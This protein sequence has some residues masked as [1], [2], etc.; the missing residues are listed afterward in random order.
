MDK[1]ILCLDFDGVIHS[2]ERGWQNGEIYGTVTSGFWEWANEARK[3]FH[4]VVYSSRSKEPEMRT[5]M[6][7]WLKHQWGVWAAAR[8][9]SDDDIRYTDLELA[10]EKPP[11]FLT[12]D[13]RAVCFQG[14]WSALDPAELRGFKPWMMRHG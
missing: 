5:A 10:S 2:Y 1:P 9:L 12:I 3:H 11:A 13:D 14:D 4:L 6:W 7:S 8:E